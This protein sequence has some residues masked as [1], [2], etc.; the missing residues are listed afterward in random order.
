MEQAPSRTEPAWLRMV[1]SASSFLNKTA[2]VA[3]AVLLVAM[4]GLILLEII[5]RY[6]SRST[7]MADALVGHGVAA[8]TFL[9]MGWALE[10]GSM[11]RISVVTRRLRPMPRFLAEAFTIVATETLVLGLI[12]FQWKAVSKLWVR[13]SVSHHHFPIPLW[14]PELIFL[15][16][17]T[18]LAIQLLVKLCRLLT[19]GMDK[20]EQLTI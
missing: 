17:L 8:T 5:L 11:I 19:L 18:L 6:F 13:G 10:K 3:A 9:A 15:V 7:F 12:Y 14:I 16:G 20:D 4:V 1:S 2:A